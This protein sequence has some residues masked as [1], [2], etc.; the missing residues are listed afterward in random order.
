MALWRYVEARTG[1]GSGYDFD[2]A[3][4]IDPVIDRITEDLRVHAADFLSG[5]P[6]TYRRLRGRVQRFAK[7]RMALS[8]A[9]Q[10]VLMP[11]RGVLWVA[12]G[13]PRRL[14]EL[15]RAMRDEHEEDPDR[16]PRES[17]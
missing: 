5:D 13:G 15:E 2:Q 3:A 17:N 1:I 4:D 14:R 12:R 8:V 7:T 10:L 6:T 11:W 9:G 16:A